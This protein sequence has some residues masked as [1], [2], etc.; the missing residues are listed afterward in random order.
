MEKWEKQMKMKA[1]PQLPESV[2]QR[3]SDTLGSLPKR[4]SYFRL[5]SSAAAVLIIGALM[6]GASYMSPT[7]AETMRSVPVIGSIFKM[8]GDVGTQK[9]EK[10]G[11]TTL[12]GQQAEINGQVITFTESLYDGSKIHIGYLIESYTQ[13][14]D[15]LSTD[16]LSDIRF[17]IDG[18]GVSYGMSANGKE[19]ENGDYAGIISIRIHDSLP[20]QFTLGIGSQKDSALNLELEITKQGENRSFLV[21]QTVETDDL[22]MHVDKVTFYPTST[23]IAFRQVMDVHTFEN[24][25]YEWLDYQ[26]VDDQGRVLQPL[27]GGG[28]GGPEKDGKLVQSMTYYFEPFEEIP[29]SLTIKPYL[30]VGNE[31]VEYVKAKWTGEN[32]TLSQGEI[33]EITVL[34]MKS[35]DGIVTL[36]VKTNGADAF[37]QAN[38]ILLEDKNGEEIHQE[39]TP[40]RVDDAVNQYEIQFDADVTE[41]DIQI[42]TYKQ[43]APNFLDELE[44]TVKVRE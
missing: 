40:K 31:N 33:G 12:L 9:G 18:K 25:K 10:E 1:N 35:E 3:I 27:S 11:L 4:K 32:V 16:F 24:K 21:N 43:N 5:Y 6:F 29:R 34:D 7:V 26:V 42:V 8:V 23:E 36:L 39:Q 37:W 22:T 28:L 15:M 41:N 44:V 30:V 38:S 17:T 20:D 2:E 19:L 13:E 14:K